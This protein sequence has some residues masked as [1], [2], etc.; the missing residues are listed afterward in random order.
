MKKQF[1][2][3]FLYFR[4]PLCG[5]RIINIEYFLK[6]LQ[7][8]KHD[9]FDC[10]IQNLILK[11]EFKRGFF[12]EFNFECNLCKKKETIY[13]ES[14]NLKES[15]SVNNAIVTATIN[16]GQGY[17]NLEQFSAI[18]DMPCMSNK[19]YQKHHE[20][21]AKQTEKIAW[22][23]IE[24]AGKEE[25]RLAIENGEVNE[26]GIPLITV[27]ADGAWSKRSYKHNYNALSGVVSS[28]YLFHDMNKLL[29]M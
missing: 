26:D 2:I 11:S 15:M 27:V 22:E 5:R 18:L 6:S 20:Y 29:L 28:H 23:S 21:I 8:I 14:P 17:S 1:S 12:S 3:I 19:T 4:Y 9:L 24:L 7:S 10:N 25:A 13:S 16:T